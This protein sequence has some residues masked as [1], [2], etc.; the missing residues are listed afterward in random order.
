MKRIPLTQGE[1]AIVSDSDFDWLSKYKWTY[2]ESRYSTGVAFRSIKINGRWLHA[3]MHRMIMDAKPGEEVDH[4]NHNRLDNRREN[5]RICTHA[6]NNWNKRKTASNSTGY[7]GIN[8][9]N[10]RWRAKIKIESKYLHLGY[11]DTK[12]EA[13]KAYD[14]AAFFYRG[15][16][17]VLNFT[18]ELPT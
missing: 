10:N 6:Q 5:L 17:A 13:A 7:I 14:R 8:K 11:F 3:Y 1:F 4:I 12:E 9:W 2:S 16:Y 18:Q 15:E